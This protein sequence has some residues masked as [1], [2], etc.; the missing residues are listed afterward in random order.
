MGAITSKF[1]NKTLNELIRFEKDEDL[2]KR[3]TLSF[4]NISN[5]NEENEVYS[6]INNGK[7]CWFS[8]KAQLVFY[9]DEEKQKVRVHE[10]LDNYMDTIHVDTLDLSNVDLSDTHKLSTNLR[11]LTLYADKIVIH[12]NF[13]CGEEIIE[14]T[15][16][17]QNKPTR[18]ETD[19][20][21]NNYNLKSL[22]LSGC[23]LQI[24]SFE[25]FLSNCSKLEEVNL[26]NI[27]LE[28]LEEDAILS[29]ENM[30]NYCMTLRKVDLTPLLEYDSNINSLAGTFRECLNLREIKGLEQFQFNNVTD[31]TYCFSG[32]TEIKSIDLSQ[33]TFKIL[34]KATGM[35]NQCFKLKTLD[36]RNVTPLQL[37]TTNIMFRGCNRLE[38]IRADKC[39]EQHNLG[40]SADEMFVGLNKNCVIH[41]DKKLKLNYY[42]FKYNLTKFIT[43]DINEYIQ[44]W[45]DF[46]KLIAN[47]VSIDNNM[48]MVLLR[49]VSFSY[50]NLD[51]SEKSIRED[52]KKVGT[53]FVLMT[54]TDEEIEAYKLKCN[55]LQIEIKHIPGMYVS[56][57][58]NSDTLTVTA[59]E[60]EYI[61]NTPEEMEFIGT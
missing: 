24:N 14:Y 25:N 53:K 10:Y 41:M 3:I 57:D 9:T 12:N 26:S 48:L 50:R 56:Y 39:Y 43:N 11:I 23:T 6:D 13:I 46:T 15:H 32:C 35:F 34:I 30:F 17:S 51:L 8:D 27:R 31:S 22:D 16:K 5:F 36:M 2:L 18:V 28:G 45:Y 59:N 60:I 55:L 7:A 33:A 40:R 29:L 1:I 54:A 37:R 19:I 58:E 20:F 4:D 49:A 61:G 21:N 44:G 52:L 38:M 42:N 47:K